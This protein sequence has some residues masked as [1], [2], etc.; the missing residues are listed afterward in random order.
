MAAA[1]RDFLASDSSSPALSP[2]SPRRRRASDGLTFSLSALSQSLVS[3]SSSDES[4]PPSS[5]FSSTSASPTSSLASS[6]SLDPKRSSSFAFPPHLHLDGPA[7]AAIGAETALSKPSSTDLAHYASTVIRNEAYALLAL[8]ARLAPAARPLLDE[9]GVYREQYEGDGS[10]TSSIEDV[11]A[12]LDL[13]D[14]PQPGGR[15]R[16][17]TD[18]VPDESR[19][20]VA[21]RQVVELVQSMPAHGKI[22]VTGVGKSGIVGRKMVATFCSLGIQSVFL[23]PLEALHGDLGV[24]CSCNPSSPCDTV[25]LISHSGATAELMRLLPIIRPRVRSLVAVTRDPD[26]VL[27]RAC[28]GWLDAGTGVYPAGLPKGTTDEADSALPAPT[29]SVVSAL[30]IGDALALTLSRLRV[31]W[32]ADGKARRQDFFYCHPGGQL[33]IQLGR[34]G[35]GIEVSPTSPIAVP[36]PAP[37]PAPAA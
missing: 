32:D 11:P 10:S 36:P 7:H 24:V 2:S 27:A 35:R 34:E 6:P 9:D 4:A 18:V 1:A 25:L 17:G 30:A 29:N 5:L 13:L 8:A 37:I 22:L 19:T 14:D 12:G 16:R 15:D 21:F 28:H 33:G 20:N 23:H 3:S 26:S 31:G